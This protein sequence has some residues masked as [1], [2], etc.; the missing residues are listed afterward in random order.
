MKLNSILMSACCLFLASRAPAF[1]LIE[2]DVQSVDSGMAHTLLLKADGTVTILGDNRYGQ[3]GGDGTF[4]TTTI[5]QV[6]AGT[7]QSL[8]L[9]VLGRV[10]VAGSNGFGQLGNGTDDHV[11]EFSLLNTIDSVSA[12]DCGGQHTLFLK[13]DRTV[14]SVGDNYFGQQG[15]AAVEYLNM[16][17]VKIM[18]DVTAVAAGD[19]HSLFLKSDGSVWGAGSNAR[20]QLGIADPAG[21]ALPVSIAGLPGRVTALAAGAYHSLFL[22]ED[23]SVWATGANDRGQLG[24]GDLSDRT[25][26]TQLPLAGVTALRAGDSH[27]LFLRNDSSL[28]A[29]GSN[30]QGQFGDPAMA[31]ASSP[32]SIAQNVQSISA[33]DASTFLVLADG[34]ALASDGGYL[35]AVG[36]EPFS[37]TGLEKNGSSFSLTWKSQARVAYTVEVSED[38]SDP[39]A[40][41]PVMSG[42]ESS[43]DGTT[44]AVIDL[45]QTPYAAARRLFLR[46]KAVPN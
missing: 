27:S 38:P 7:N 42:I 18:E 9:D 25:T 36:I 19:R 21:S 43:G 14:W 41:T 16:L 3:I 15:L 45:S 32:V 31:S 6:V 1:T 17:P 40:W 8:L 11:M 28:W 46:V 35:P 24:L 4:D 37:V 34:Q 39:Q 13:T 29:A 30:D 23:G 12:I 5:K 20:G 2:S 44:G 33:G 10:W 22:I 26:P